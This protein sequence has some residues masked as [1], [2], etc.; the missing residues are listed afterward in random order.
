M[1]RSCYIT[2]YSDELA[3]FYELGKEIETYQTA[4]ELIDKTRHLLA[5]PADAE[6]MR[7]AGYRRA[8]QD[9]TWV[10]RFEQLFQEIGVE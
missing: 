9:H 10:R 2:G 8:R 7:E 4:E 5:H 6:R 1:S 3:E